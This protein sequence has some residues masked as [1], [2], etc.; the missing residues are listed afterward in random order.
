[1]GLNTFKCVDNVW[2]QVQEDGTLIQVE[3]IQCVIELT[4]T[5]IPTTQPPL[6][7]YQCNSSFP[8]NYPGVFGE[9]I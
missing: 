5:P 8:I 7:P 1:M 6:C 4:T 2:M 9:Y 3:E